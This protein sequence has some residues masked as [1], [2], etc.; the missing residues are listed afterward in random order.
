MKTEPENRHSII[1]PF[2]V[3]LVLLAFA[4]YYAYL[5]LTGRHTLRP[6]EGV[7]ALATAGMALFCI[8]LL[9]QIRRYYRDSLERPGPWPQGTGLP[10]R[11]APGTE[12]IS[13]SATENL[14]KLK[15]LANQVEV[16]SAMREISLLASQDVNFERLVEH[17]LAHVEQLIGTSEI[18]LFLRSQ[19]D[20]NVLRAQ[21]RRL[22]GKTLFGSKIDLAAVDS[23]HVAQVARYGNVKREETAKTLDLTVPVMVDREIL[24][25][26]KAKIGKEET[27]PEELERAELNL[28]NILSHIGLAIKT[29]TL[30]DRATLDSLTGLYTKR[31]MTA[32]LSKL[33]AGCRRLSKSLAVI[34][35]DIDHFKNINDTHG[36]LTGDIV[37][38]EVA[39]I[40]KQQIREYDSAYRYGGEEICIL[41]PDT[42]ARSAVS[43]A[44]RIRQAIEKAR[45]RGDR[46]QKVP[47]TISGGVAV[48]K[49]YMN[50]LE[51]IIAE[52]DS[53]LYV[54]KQ[55]GRNQIKYSKQRKRIE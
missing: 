52:A 26:V 35:L 45:L 30:Y 3:C 38:R 16:L 25:A 48:F 11:P 9:F 2:A 37:L 10:E 23:T 15:N 13:A 36:H 34:M 6:I 20:K 22:D 28:R 21:A 43:V 41:L 32:E 39:G 46:N 8:L 24:G 5:V 27:S 12:D 7:M 49:K 1:V 42:A 19:E 47:V 50:K 17:A 51:N 14:S 31:H 18:T 40:I 54:A 55:S 44:E 4:G 33:F 53:A 29:P